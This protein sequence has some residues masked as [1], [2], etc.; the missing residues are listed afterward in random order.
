[1]EMARR[2]HDV[3]VV[4]AFPN[5]PAGKLY[6]G[7]KR[8]LF[9]SEQDEN[10][11]RV[12][13]CFAVLS[14]RSSMLSRFMENL[15]FGVVSGWVCLFQPHTDVIYSITW[16][17]FATTILYWIA[18]LRN[19]PIVGSIQDVY[20]ESLI[21]Q[22]RITPNSLIARIFCW[23]DGWVA[24]GSQAIILISERF[25][26]LYRDQR[27]VP[28]SKIHV[29]PNWMDSRSVSL[30]ISRQVFRAKKGIADDQFLIVY[31]GNISVAAG[32]D[33]VVRA[34]VGLNQDKVCLLI[35]GSGSQLDRCQKL[36]ST[37]SPQNVIFH[38]PWLQSEYSEVLRS[39]DI[40]ILP[41]QGDQSLVSVPSK[42]ISYLLSARPVLAL[43]CPD[44]EL[45]QVIRSVQCGWVV[46][47]DR[48]DLCAE[49]IQE[50]CA[51]PCEQ[52]EAM[53]ARGR[54]YVLSNLTDEVNLPR[55]ADL[56]EKAA[57]EYVRN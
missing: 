8:H 48:P 51:Y 15:S 14:P 11:F 19:I 17:I 29:I 9:Q 55:V 24:R 34:M 49:M 52:L 56:L 3:T 12:F 46:D 44:S 37:F 47:P 41:T 36:A 2:G 27:R 18:R 31:A 25:V 7:Y 54:Q 50:I 45:A 13:R 38:S 35:A 10:G 21:S 4:T 16:P 43:A 23:I 5:R 28:M 33:T 1:M 6:P 20:P 53:G 57:Q 40:L 30:E 26:T 42:L 32:V 22:K 39:A